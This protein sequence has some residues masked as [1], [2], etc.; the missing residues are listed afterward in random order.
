MPARLNDPLSYLRRHRHHPHHLKSLS[1]S[2]KQ[3]NKKPT[4][5]PARMS[6]RR[7]NVKYADKCPACF[8]IEPTAKFSGRT[9]WTIIKCQRGLNYLGTVD[10]TDKLFFTDEFLD[11]VNEY[12]KKLLQDENHLAQ[13]RDFNRMHREENNPRTQGRATR[14]TSLPVAPQHQ[15]PQQQQPT[16]PA[17]VFHN[18]ETTPNPFTS[19]PFF[20]SPPTYA[21]VAQRQANQFLISR[22]PPP[23]NVVRP[24][25][26]PIHPPTAQTHST[27]RQQQ[28][29]LEYKGHPMA[30][31]REGNLHR[32]PL[33]PTG[34][35]Q[36][37]NYNPGAHQ[38][39]YFD[40]S[41]VPEGQTPRLI[42]GPPGVCYHDPSKVQ[43]AHNDQ[44]QQP[45]PP[46]PGEDS[47]Q[48]FDI[49]ALAD[50]HLDQTTDPGPNSPPAQRA[51]DTPRPPPKDSANG[52]N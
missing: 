24:Q 21:Q 29:T 6:S 25:P 28:S 26:V 43:Q 45:Q 41:P 18:I 49:Q 14:P 11:K 38:C 39:F 23:V 35:P 16:A 31:D 51:S 52:N 17:F 8:L 19:G 47:A 48:S 20:A 15:Q 3:I 13:H 50:Q 2:S 46:P 7:P 10:L 44:Q 40:P 33:G 1:N 27:D 42:A 30:Y 37:P 36:Q 12:N 4:F 9:Q 34:Q 22:P 32:L 5:I